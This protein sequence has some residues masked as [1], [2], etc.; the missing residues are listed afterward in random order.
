VDPTKTFQ[1]ACSSALHVTA[2][3]VCLLSLSS[4][5]STFCSSKFLHSFC[6]SE[7]CT[8]CSSGK[9]S[10]RLMSIVFIIF[11]WWSKFRVHIKEWGQP[12]HC[13]C[14]PLLY[15]CAFIVH[16]CLYCTRVPLL[17]TCAFIVH[18][19]PY[20]TRVPLLYTCAFIVHV[21]LYY[22]RVPLLYTCA[23]IVHV[24]PYSWKL[25]NHNWFKSVA[26][27]SQCLRKCCQYLLDVW[28][29]GGA[30][31]EALRYKPE[32]RG[33]DSWWCHCSFYWHNPSGCTMV[34]GSTQP[35]TE[36]STRNISWG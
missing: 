19:Y 26:Y 1:A 7:L 29:R 17:Y 6:G 23:F 32:S 24:Y 4:A 28:A 8:G 31:V 3:F 18:V 12:V 10:S 5:G 2:G 20:Y 35:L 25:L 22:T 16:V 15:T 11:L 34:L 33:I 21:C 27:S 36:M 14:V 9:L 13:T 30:V